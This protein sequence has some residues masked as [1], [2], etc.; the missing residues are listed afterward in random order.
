VRRALYVLVAVAILGACGSTVPQAQR[1]AAAGGAGLDGAEVTPNDELAGGEAAGTSSGAA[2]GT[3]ASAGGTRGSTGS[4]SA[5]G[6]GG[7]TA[8]TGPI[9]IGMVRTGVSNAAAFGASLGNTVTEAEIYDAIVS[10]MNERG[11][12][13]GRRIVPVYDDTD[14]AS[15]NWDADFEAACAKFTQDNKVVAVLGYVFTHSEPFEG[16]LSSRGIPHLSTTFNVPDAQVLARYALLVPLSTPRI[17]RRSQVKIDGGLATGVLTKA[18]RLGVVIDSC[19]GTE[20]AWKQFTEPYLEA[21]GITVASIAQLGCANGAGDAGAEAGRVGNVILQFRTDGVDTIVANAVSEG[22][23]VLVFANAAEAQGWRPKYVVT[24]LAN[25]AVLQGQIPNNQAANV[26]G[27][28]WL[29]SQDVSPTRWPANPPGA[30]RCIGLVSSKGV[31]LQAAA[32]FAFAFNA[33]EALFVYERALEATGNRTDGAA[34]VAAIEDLGANYS[35]VLTLEGRLAFA[36]GKRDGPS[37]ARYF[38]WDGGCS[39]F[40][41]RPTTIPIQ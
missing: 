32:D 6:G 4:G 21:K 33:C 31:K 40:T 27:Y 25:A 26:H 30:E 37:L 2:A 11:G 18:T 22:P 35:G 14:T 5:G 41:Y 29:P 13:N 19:P 20:R 8:T 9:T 34:V 23:G 39:C 3:G 15:N 1:R 17:E 28:G 36:K 12:L 7:A 38:A 10:A 16:C 24:S